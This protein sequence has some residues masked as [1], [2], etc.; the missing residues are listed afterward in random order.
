[1]GIKFLSYCRLKRRF[2]H[3][4]ETNINWDIHCPTR[5]RCVF[6]SAI[7]VQLP[8]SWAHDDCDPLKFCWTL[9]LQTGQSLQ[10]ILSGKWFF[11]YVMNLTAKL[12]HLQKFMIVAF[13]LSTPKCIMHVCGNEPCTMGSE[14]RDLKKGFSA[15]TV[16]SVHNKPPKRQDKQGEKR[17]NVRNLYDSWKDKW[18]EDVTAPN[19]D[20]AYRNKF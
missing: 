18:R 3:N 13:A 6:T 2:R 9:M 16:I 10:D 11:V 15:S 20:F 4:S 8:W 12:V 19:D 7:F 5:N 17:N 14:G 1:M